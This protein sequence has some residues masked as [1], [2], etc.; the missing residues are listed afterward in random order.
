MTPAL[1]PNQPNHSSA[2]PSITSGTLWG[3]WMP[4]WKPTRFPSTIASASAAA[5]ELMCTAVPPAQSITSTP[6]SGNIIDPRLKIQPPPHTHA[7]TGK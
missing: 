6:L 1:K 7:A 5:P 2:P 4:F 3:F